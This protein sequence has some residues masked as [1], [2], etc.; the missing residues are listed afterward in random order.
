MTYTDRSR[1]TEELQGGEIATFVRERQ[2]VVTKTTTY[3]I[4]A[5][6]SGRDIQASVAGVGRQIRMRR[7]HEC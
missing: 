5:H 6:A 1:G 2:G 4:K 7:W 3:A